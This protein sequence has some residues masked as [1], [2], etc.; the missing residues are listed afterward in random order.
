MKKNCTIFFI[1]LI[2]LSFLLFLNEYFYAGPYIQQ[3]KIFFFWKLFEIE[4][5][6][7]NS[8]FKGTSINKMNF[9][10]K[11]IEQRS[12]NILPL[13]FFIEI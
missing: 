4:I 6:I 8:I 2:F 7:I 9:K 3:K 1:Q 10:F 13:P 12:K 5:L 11:I